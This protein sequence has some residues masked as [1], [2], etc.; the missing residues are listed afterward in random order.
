MVE[1]H[2]VIGGLGSAVAEF[3]SGFCPRKVI[4]IGLQDRFPESGA[5]EELYEKYGI[6]P[7]IIVEKALLALK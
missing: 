6:T 2:T 4:R 1:D 3:A 7:K 5:P